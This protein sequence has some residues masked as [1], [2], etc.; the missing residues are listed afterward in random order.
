MVFVEMAVLPARSKIFGNR[1]VNAQWAAP[2]HNQQ[3]ATKNA[4]NAGYGMPV[5]VMVSSIRTWFLAQR[6]C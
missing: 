6:L 3:Q 5:S 1:M 4:I 2:L